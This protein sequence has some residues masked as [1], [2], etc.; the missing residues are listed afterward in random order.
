MDA[1]AAGAG[2]DAIGIAVGRRDAGKRVRKQQP[3]TGGGIAQV[4]AHAGRDPVLGHILDGLA[5]GHVPLLDLDHVLGLLH[6]HHVIGG[7]AVGGVD[8]E[9]LSQL[10]LG[11][12]VTR[13]FVKQLAVLDEGGRLDFFLNDIL[14][15][16]E[17]FLVG[18]PAPEL[19]EPRVNGLQLPARR[20]IPRRE[21]QHALHLLARLG[22]VAAGG[23]F[24]TQGQAHTGQAL[25]GGRALGVD[26]LGSGADRL[27]PF[28][29]FLIKDGG[30]EEVAGV[31]DGPGLIQFVAK[32]NDGCLPSHHFLGRIL[33]R[34]LCLRGWQDDDTQ[35][36]CNAGCLDRFDHDCLGQSVKLIGVRG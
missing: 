5:G 24:I 10:G 12:V 28:L 7:A 2:V 20:E 33:G 3:L 6:Q 11:L 21:H 13:H 27:D 29:R 36:Q 14:D 31:L 34:C 16:L 15:R 32:F 25:D 30:R 17:G 18:H 26:P 4:E 9:R 22:E 23:I 35:K 8:R 19:L 1:H